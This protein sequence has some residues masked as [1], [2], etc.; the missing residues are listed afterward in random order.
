MS[1]QKNIWRVVVPIALLVLVL[2]ATFGVVWH[3]HVDSSCDTCPLCHLTI[4]PA[5]VGI[6]LCVLVPTGV[7]SAPHY[8]SLITRSALRQIPARAPPV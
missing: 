8:I 7:G 5:T 6:H 4:T 1:D 2:I 3:H